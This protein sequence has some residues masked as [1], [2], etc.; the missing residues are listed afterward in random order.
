[1]ELARG[2]VQRK[3]DVPQT[4]TKYFGEGAIASGGLQYSPAVTVGSTSGV[5]VFNELIDPGYLLKCQQIKVDLTFKP[6][7]L[8]SVAGSLIFHWRAKSDYRG[9]GWFDPDGAHGSIHTASYVTITGATMG[10]AIGSAVSN[11]YEYPVSGYLPIAS[12][13]TS[14]IRIQLIAQNTANQFTAQVKNTSYIQLIGITI[15]GA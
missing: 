9:L 8:G 1:M 6:T 11:T 10:G 5:T 4:Y 13:P 3:I 12:L 15:P 2:M 7:H 14:P